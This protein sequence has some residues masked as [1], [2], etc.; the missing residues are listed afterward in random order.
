MSGFRSNGAENNIP[1]R[2]TMRLEMAIKSLFINRSARSNRHRKG[3]VNERMIQELR[4]S[5]LAGDTSPVQ[6]AAEAITR[7]NSNSGKNVYIS[8]DPSRV[9]RDAEA[10]PAK[11]PSPEKPSLYGLPVSLKDCFD[12]TGFATSCGSK[13]YAEQ[14]GIAQ[15]D[16]AVAARLR[17]QGAVIVGKTNLHQLAYGITGENPDYG[18]CAQPRDA[19]RF[20]G[21]SS[22]G[23]AASVQEGSAVAG[24]GTDTGGSIRAPA[25]LCGLAGYRA[26]IGLADERGLWRGGVHLA[27]PF[28]TL[29]W[30]FRDLRDAPLLA[31]GL[32][33]LDVE[34][35][36]PKPIRIASVDDRFLHDC[37]LAVLEVFQSWQERLIGAGAELTPFDATFWE[38]A[39]DIFAPI[40]AQEATA[41]HTARTGGDFSH[42]D[43]AIASR[44]AWGASLDP[45][46]VSIC[47]RRH[48]EFREKVDALLRQY[49][50]LIVPCSPV[51]RLNIGADNSQSRRRILRYTVPM[52]LTGAPVVTLPDPSGAGVQLAAQRGDDARLL[53]FAAQLDAF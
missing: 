14:S 52:S 47:R 49:D 24:I 45:A 41:I 33:G 38:E 21:G 16:S 20:T 19:S 30:L 17:A 3:W 6:I 32:F 39:M 11:F 36:S 7:I 25:A 40:Q 51:D 50:F 48:A 8:F 29:G 44:L 28:D 31:K 37:E 13:F 46:E 42:F 26:S 12:L 9:M 15:K 2:H 18:D 27:Q 53:A 22:S 10:L 5:V 1:N 4:Q 35:H 23:S 43:P 34:A